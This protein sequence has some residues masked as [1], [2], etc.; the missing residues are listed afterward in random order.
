[1]NLLFSYGV[2]SALSLLPFSTLDAHQ[3]EKYPSQVKVTASYPRFSFMYVYMTSLTYLGVT[4]CKQRYNNSRC[5]YS[6]SKNT[7]KIR[8]QLYVL[9][10]A[11]T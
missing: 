4:S 7:S 9:S 2:L 6:E 1:M 3:N 11:S 10:I 5:K 8:A